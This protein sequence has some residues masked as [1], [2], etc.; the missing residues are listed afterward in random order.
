MKNQNKED[1]LKNSHKESEDLENLDKE[2]KDIIS[3][4]EALNVSIKKFIKD[5][6]KEESKNK[7]V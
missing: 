1:K 7:K 4:N 6:S 2:L 3:T 5:I